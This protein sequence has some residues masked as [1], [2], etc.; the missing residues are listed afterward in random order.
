M[1][2]W[3]E[4]MKMRT[5]EEMQETLRNLRKDNAERERAYKRLYPLHI[6]KDGDIEEKLEELKHALHKRIL[7]AGQTILDYEN[8]INEVYGKCDGHF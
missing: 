3:R 5:K 1:V 8:L 4:N 2:G 6:Q 7:D